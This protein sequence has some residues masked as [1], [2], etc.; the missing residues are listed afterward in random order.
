MIKDFFLAQIWNGTQFFSNDG[1][2]LAGGKVATYLAGSMST[3][4][5]TYADSMGDVVNPNPIV[6][7]SSGRIP[8]DI[9][10]GV[11]DNYQFV[12]YQPDG[13]TVIMAVDNVGTSDPFPDQTGADGLFLGSDGDV[14]GWERVLPNQAGQAGKVLSTDGST[15]L[16][17]LSWVAQT[18][19]GGGGGSGPQEFIAK[20]DAVSYPAMSTGYPNPYW[21]STVYQESDEVVCNDFY[22][23]DPI[24]FTLDTPG[25][26]KVTI[27]GR[28]RSISYPEGSLPS[29]PM[30]YGCRVTNSMASFTMSSHSSG[31]ASD[32]PW[33]TSPWNQSMCMWTDI[34][35]VENYDGGQTFSIE[36]FANTETQTF[37]YIP[38]MQVSVVRT[39][40]TVWPQQYPA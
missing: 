20:L 4:V 27:Q 36:L 38:A 37:E 15:T 2:P 34:F 10:L 39:S 26:Y 1:L 8:T 14:V 18:G 6:L 22:G 9:W 7:D 28:I 23:G 25:I 5:Y 29:E 33:S 32:L 13:T 24:E 16:G 3:Q 21:Y 30:L 12:L 40:G 31:E 19:G 35:Y 17:N 11:N